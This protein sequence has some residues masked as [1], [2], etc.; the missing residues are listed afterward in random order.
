MARS[1]AELARRSANVQRRVLCQMCFFGSFAAP[2]T[3]RRH[4]ADGGAEVGFG[5]HPWR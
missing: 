4:A 5:R 3:R 2:P 1:A